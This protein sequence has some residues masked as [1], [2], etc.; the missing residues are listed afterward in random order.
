[1]SS[2]KVWPNTLNT[3]LLLTK[4][5]PLLFMHQHRLLQLTEHQLLQLL[6]LTGLLLL[7][8]LRPINL[9]RLCRWHTEDNNTLFIRTMILSHKTIL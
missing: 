1:M 6:L 4:L 5:Q 7:L 3:R 9:C 8:L 2:T